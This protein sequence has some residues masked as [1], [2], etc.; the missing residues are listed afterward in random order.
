MY[1]SIFA[2]KL[3]LAERSNHGWRVVKIKLLL[4]FF[5]ARRPY[6]LSGEGSTHS[7][8]GPAVRFL[9]Y[10]LISNT[11]WI[12]PLLSAPENILTDADGVDAWPPNRVT[13]YAISVF[14][15]YY[16]SQPIMTALT[17]FRHVSGVRSFDQCPRYLAEGEGGVTG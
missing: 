8:F 12:L 10:K 17:G 3:L 2:V 5:L 16:L 4:L 6:P 1:A 13:R 14:C 11:M 15:V 7:R 9:K